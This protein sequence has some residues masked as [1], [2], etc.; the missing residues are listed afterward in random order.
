M[1]DGG[2]SFGGGGKA[3]LYVFPFFF[4]AFMITFSS[5]SA[6]GAGQDDFRYEIDIPRPLDTQEEIANN[7]TDRPVVNTNIADEDRPEKTVVY[8]TITQHLPAN[9]SE[10]L[11]KDCQEHGYTITITDE[12]CLSYIAVKQQPYFL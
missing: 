6:C 7:E 1:G 3:S 9:I 5:V 10:E 8:I 12:P 11:I 2:R 4:I